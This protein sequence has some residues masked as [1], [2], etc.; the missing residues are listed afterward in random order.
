MPIDVISPPTKLSIP[1]RYR[2]KIRLL[3]IAKHALGDGSRDK[4]D[5]D[6]A[7]Y[8]REVRDVLEGM[9]LNVTAANSP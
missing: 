9:G 5:G 4:V 2:D 1:S 7:V 3:F 8:H 6:H